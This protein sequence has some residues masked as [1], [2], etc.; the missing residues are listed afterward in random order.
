M[1]ATGAELIMQR[2]EANFSRSFEEFAEG[3]LAERMHEV[4][5]KE[6]LG[7]ER[8]GPI[9]RDGT[10]IVAR[11]RPTRTATTVGEAPAKKPACRQGRLRPGEL[12]SPAKAS[13]LARRRRQPVAQMLAE[14]P[15][16]CERGTQCNTQG[17]RISWNGYKLHLDTADCGVPVAALLSS[18]SMHDSWAALPLSRMSAARVTNLYD[19]MDAAYCSQEIREDSLS[20]GQVPLIDHLPRRARRSS[21]PRPKPSAP[22][23]VP[24]PNAAMPSVVLRSSW[25]QDVDWRG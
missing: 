15:T 21:S 2:S 22:T 11:E 12:R 16:L 3:R 9:S 20:L 17:Y 14:M 8:V 7:D 6:H 23:S 25:N 13:P 19:L 18:A 10:A 5:V 24:L 4:L 1:D